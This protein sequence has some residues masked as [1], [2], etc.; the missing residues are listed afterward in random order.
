[1]FR[2]IL[3]LGD[4]GQGCAERPGSR[5][6]G[7]RRS[8]SPSRHQAARGSNLSPTTCAIPGGRPEVSW[9]TSGL[10]PGSGPEGV[11]AA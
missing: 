6:A 8:L 10:R 7:G 1:M 11:A 5:L 2:L 9:A 3:K 4:G